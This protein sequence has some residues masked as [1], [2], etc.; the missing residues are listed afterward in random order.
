MA[1]AQI[2]VEINGVKSN[3]DT[4]ARLARKQ[5][6]RGT[7]CRAACEVISL[8]NTTGATVQFKEFMQPISRNRDVINLMEN[9]ENIERVFQ[10]FVSPPSPQYSVLAHVLS[11]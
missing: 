5:Q 10:Q 4:A 2:E 11:H 3:C 8:C 7:G 6:L 9:G 1:W